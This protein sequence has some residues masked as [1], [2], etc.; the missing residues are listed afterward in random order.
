MEIKHI[1][2]VLVDISGY[3]RF[4]EWNK[5]TLLHAEMIITE[6]LEAVISKAEYPLKL[7]KLE[8]DA[9]L[10]FTPIDADPNAVMQDV[11]KQVI[12]FFEAFKAKRGQLADNTACPCDSC[13]NISTLNLKAVLHCGQVV[14][15]Q[16][17][18]FEEL[19]GSDVILIHRLLKNSIPSREY[20]AMTE[21]FYQPLQQSLNL[22]M[23]KHNET[24]DSL[25]KVE[26]FV[27]YPSGAPLTD[28]APV[29]GHTP[30]AAG[31]I[32]KMQ[33]LAE[34]IWHRWFARKRQ[35]HNLPY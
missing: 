27:H 12:N 24:Y 22:S 30:H 25:G 5:N 2:L 14:I 34:I 11:A 7:N 6:L 20:I 3:T 16:V 23:V 10:L 9:A 19:A 1:A 15:K 13:Q 4:L 8:G 32:G 18:Q 28:G 35:F 26:L 29:A 17:R 33:L 31:V 21:A